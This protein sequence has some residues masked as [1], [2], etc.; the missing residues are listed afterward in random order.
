MI[1]TPPELRFLMPQPKWSPGYNNC[2]GGGVPCAKCSDTT[3]GSYSITFSD[4]TFCSCLTRGASY[5]KYVLQNGAINTTFI[6]D[7]C[8]TDSCAW[9]YEGE[10]DD[11]TC[12]YYTDNSC[13][14]HDFD[15]DAKIWVLMNR[16]ESAWFQLRMHAEIEAD[17]GDFGTDY[18]DRLFFDGIV[19]SANCTVTDLAATSDLT[20]SGGTWDCDDFTNSWPWGCSMSTTKT[21]KESAYGGTALI[22]SI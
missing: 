2:C 14:T 3:P 22:T 10:S 21:G 11:L 12:K 4:I 19:S 7:Q 15:C 1:W 8:P 16:T 5:Y 20:S 18:L 13:T 9:E 6:L 17:C